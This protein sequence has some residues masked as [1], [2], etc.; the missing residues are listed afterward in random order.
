[1]FKIMTLWMAAALAATAA[2]RASEAPAG[3]INGV[4]NAFTLNY[5]PYSDTVKLYQNGIRLT[6]GMDFTLS[7]QSLTLLTAPT[8]GDSLLADYDILLPGGFHMLV[9]KA[10]GACLAPSASAGKLLP[11]SCAGLDSQKFSAA[12]G[13]GGSVFTIKSSNQ[14]MDLLNAGVADGTPVLQSAPSGNRSQ[15]WQPIALD[16]DSYFELA[17]ALTNSGSCL[18]LAGT[19]VVLQAC[20]GLDTQKWQWQ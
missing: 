11:A 1:M 6:A 4:N 16:H 20:T 9:N 7:G 2:Q 14:A 15:G 19:A 5:L 18:T 12:P 3:A 17:N 8:A 13:P 10:T